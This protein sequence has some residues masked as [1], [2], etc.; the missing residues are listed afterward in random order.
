MHVRHECASY[1]IFL[2]S[3]ATAL[4]CSYAAVL[5]SNDKLQIYVCNRISYRGSHRLVTLLSVMSASRSILRICAVAASGS[6][7]G[8]Y[9]NNPVLPPDK[10]DSRRSSS[11][12]AGSVPAAPNEQS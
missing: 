8:R 1:F 3:C 11:Q 7:A 9:N 6:D 5:S 10:I 4:Y 2:R 12:L